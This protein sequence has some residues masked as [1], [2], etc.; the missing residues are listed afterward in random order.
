MLLDGIEEEMSITS[1]GLQSFIN[2]SGDTLGSMVQILIEDVDESM[3]GLI[4]RLVNMPF[5]SRVS[6]QGYSSQGGDSV[7]ATATIK[8]IKL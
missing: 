2:L 4:K 6:T 7:S 1:T 3:D 5:G 8:N